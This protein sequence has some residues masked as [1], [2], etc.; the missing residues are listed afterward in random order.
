MKLKAPKHRVFLLTSLLIV[1][2]ITALTAL[3][4]GIH[5]D[6]RRGNV[7][8]LVVKDE[9]LGFGEVWEYRKFLWTVP[10]KNLRTNEVKVE[11]STSC[12]CMEVDPP[13]LV[14]PSGETREIRLSLD[15]K[16]KRSDELQTQWHDFSVSVR[17]KLVGSQQSLGEWVVHGKVRS[18]IRCERT[19]IDLGRHSE[20]AQPL[21]PQRLRVTS[22]IPLRALKVESTF[23]FLK[24]E[25]NKV[26]DDPMAYEL[27]VHPMKLPKGAIN[28]QVLV[29]PELADGK[30]HSG[31]EIDVIGEVVDDIQTSPPEALLGARR[32]GAIVEETVTLSSLTGQS[33]KVTSAKAEG[34]G[35]TVR[36]RSSEN[37]DGLVFV[38][39]V[40]QRAAKLGQQS[41]RILFRVT[42]KTGEA[43]EVMMPVSYLGI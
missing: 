37:E 19:V 33:F 28:T 41:G 9:D 42:G 22:F 40:T 36:S 11:F 2:V 26:S 16:P 25:L 5:G 35:L 27:I 3:K 39:V 29:L 24:A 38:F 6:T 20:L 8:G 7:K 13:S 14:L 32:V 17:P 1:I 31:R 10:V 15:L 18:A 43:Y 21:A 34:D 23:Q 30:P 12:S 4:S